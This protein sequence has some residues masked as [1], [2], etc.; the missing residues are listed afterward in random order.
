MMN[1]KYLLG[2]LLIACAVVLTSAHPK[3]PI[4]FSKWN[5]GVMLQ[6]YYYNTFHSRNLHT[7]MSF[8]LGLCQEFA[9]DG[10]KNKNFFSIG[11]EYLYQ[12]FSFQSYYF[13]QDTMRLYN[14]KMDYVYDVKLSE[15]NVPFLYKYNFS[16]ENNDVQGIFFSIGYVYRILLPSIVSISHSGIHT[17]S[18]TLRPTFKI[19]VL[20]DYCNSYAHVSIGFQKNN[21]QGKTKMFVEIFGRYGFSP[22]YI[23]T[24]NTA[25]NLFFGNYFIGMSV[26]MKWRK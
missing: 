7:G 9:L 2:G 16:R 4:R 22:F 19:P 26:G 17:S 21:P 23:K 12:S 18:E 20:N 3:Y 8:M 6:R 14:G 10:M 24:Q 1:R 25:S 15:V 11:V 5:A 13:T